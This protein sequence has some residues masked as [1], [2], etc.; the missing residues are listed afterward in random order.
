M[1]L[2]DPKMERGARAACLLVGRVDWADGVYNES[3]ASSQ[4][5]CP[6]QISAITSQAASTCSGEKVGGGGAQEQDIS[7][8]SVLH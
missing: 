7:F 8:S 6:Y 5:G 2:N 3:G 4:Q 1:Y